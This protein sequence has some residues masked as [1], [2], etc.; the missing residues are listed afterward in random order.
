MDGELSSEDYQR[1]KSNISKRRDKTNTKLESLNPQ[2]TSIGQKLEHVFNVIRNM[3]EILSSGRMEHK[4]QL[5]GS[6][7]PEKIEFDGEKYRTSSYSKV[8]EWIFQNTNELEKEKTEDRDHKPLSSVSVPGAG[9]QTFLLYF[10][11]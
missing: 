6:M 4:I 3:P 2:N 10:P 8:L 7:F 5:L 1:M 11:E 9:L